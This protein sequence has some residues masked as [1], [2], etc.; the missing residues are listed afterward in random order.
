MGQAPSSSVGGGAGPSL[1]TPSPS[2][3][4][5]LVVVVGRV[6]SWVLAA[7]HGYSVGGWSWSFGVRWHGHVGGGSLRAVMR[8]AVVLCDDEQ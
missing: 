8:F 7:V 1:S 5:A 2:F 4:C 6:V 3:V